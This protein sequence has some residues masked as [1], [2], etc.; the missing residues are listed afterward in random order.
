M[1]CSKFN[2]KIIGLMIDP[3]IA[4]IRRERLRPGAIRVSMYARQGV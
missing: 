4:R 1:G 2:N 3:A